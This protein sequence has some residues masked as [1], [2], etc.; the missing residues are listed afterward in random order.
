VPVRL[1]LVEYT[2]RSRLVFFLRCPRDHPALH[3]FP[4]R[5]SSDLADIGLTFLRAQVDAGVDAVQLFYSWAG[6]L[7]L[8]EYREFVLPHS[9][10]S[11]EHTSEL[12]SRENLVCRLLLEKKK[13]NN[14]TANPPHQIATS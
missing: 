12:Q 6:A 1:M 10:R 7:S 14:N 3:S 11:E 4:T 5:R 13:N 2:S 9:A 8:R